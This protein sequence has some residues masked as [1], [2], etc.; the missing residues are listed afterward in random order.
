VSAVESAGGGPGPS[1]GVA[2]TGND[3]VGAVA[4]RPP[5]AVSPE[6]TL[7]A[8][9]RLLAD[10]SVG[11]VVVRRVHPAGSPA[12]DAIGIVSERD[13]SRAV[14]DGLDPTRTRAVDV[15]TTE[16]AHA[17]PD[18]TI[19]RVAARM[20][21]NEVRHL[22]VITKSGE[23]IGVISE[24]DVLRALVQAWRDARPA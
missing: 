16:L 23:L 5:V 11:A 15:M 10:E 7:Q 21:A 20:I 22:P 3:T 17:E 4:R 19:L 6:T 1:P 9:A 24:R 2:R 14:A 18:D 8:V 13:I 12:D